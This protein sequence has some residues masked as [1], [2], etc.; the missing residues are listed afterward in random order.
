MTSPARIAIQ[1]LR[2]TLRQH[3]VLLLVAADLSYEEM[4]KALNIS[5][6][7]VRVHV[8][9]ILQQ[10][11]WDPNQPALR[12]LRRWVRAIPTADLTL[13]ESPDEAEPADLP[14]H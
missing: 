1:G 3:E 6:A 8:N 2:L 10:I 9:A 7:T 11:E 14:T 12:Q 4:G 13:T 5:P